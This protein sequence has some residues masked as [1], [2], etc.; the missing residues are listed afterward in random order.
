[1]FDALRA[2]RPND[3]KPRLVLNFV[4]VAKRPDITTKDFA[5]AVEAEPLAVIPFEPK[6]FGTAANNGQMI[7]E[8]EPNSKI[9]DLLDDIGRAVLGKADIRKTKRALLDP[10]MSRLRLKA[11]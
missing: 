7:A 6:L 5:K 10:L 2:A 3:S 4:G 8:I 11:S 9:S 1:M